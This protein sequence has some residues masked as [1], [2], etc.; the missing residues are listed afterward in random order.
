ME[1]LTLT[2]FLNIRSVAVLWHLQQLLQRTLSMR[3]D[4]N[5]KQ[6]PIYDRPFKMEMGMGI[7]ASLRPF[8]LRYLRPH[9]QVLCFQLETLLLA[10]W[11]SLQPDLD[12]DAL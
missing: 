6:K 10:M 1:A 11:I 4:G 2:K 5:E 9:G 3:R 8:R 7:E 12:S